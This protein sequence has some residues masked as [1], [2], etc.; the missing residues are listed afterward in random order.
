MTTSSPQPVSRARVISSQVV[1]CLALDLLL[2]DLGMS[3][4]FVTMVLPEVLDAP[5]GLSINEY[6]ASW[7]GSMAFMCQ[8]LGSIFSGPILDYFGRRKALFIVNLPHLVAWLMMY[9]SWNVPSLFLANALLGIGTGI[10]E[11]PSVTY[12]G[13]VSDPS[14]R[15]ILTTLTN[16]FTSTGVFLAYLLGTVLP[17]RSAA[18]VSLAVP[19]TSMALVTLVPETPIWLLSKGRQKEALRSLCQLRGWSKPEDVKEEF[20]HLVQYNEMLQRCVICAKNGKPTINP[21]Q[22]SEAPMFKR[23]ML[24]IKHILLA[25]E[26]LRPFALVMAYFLFY[27]MSGLLPIRPNMVNVCKALGMKYDAKA[28]VVMVGAVFIVMNLLSAAI[29]KFMGKRKLVISSMLL[30]SCCSLAISVYAGNN[31]GPEVFSYEAHTF[32]E[33]TGILP[34]VLFM[35]LVCF[36]SLGIPWVLLSEVFPFRSRGIATS[37]A[38]AF[39]Y[40]ISFLAAKSNYNIEA[41]FHISGTFGIYSIFGLFG[42]IYLYFFLPETENKSL[43]EIETFYQGEHRIFADDFLINAFRKKKGL[44]TG[45]TEPMLV[46]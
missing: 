7:F 9:Y 6:Q 43:L 38:A 35:M 45:A 21:C 17:W 2:V 24:N 41:L 11:A 36:T 23:M 25:K 13:E 18:L 20:E 29:V 14:V 31:L 34:V 39:S 33:Q 42:T 4:S 8:P 10:M 26:T 27:T 3:I 37:L 46:K 5:E 19:L 40:V 15:G 28:I 12:V 32:P 1:A 16:C 22:H 44:S 30:T